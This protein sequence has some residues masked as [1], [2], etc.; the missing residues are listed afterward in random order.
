MAADPVFDAYGA[1]Y[2]LFYRDKPYDREVAWLTERIRRYHPSAHTLLDLGCGTGAYTERFAQA[3][4][5]VWGVDLSPQMIERAQQGKASY[6]VGDARRFQAE[7]PVDIATLLFHVM[8]YQSTDDDVI[9]TLKT[10]YDNLKEGGLLCF[11]VWHKP[12]VLAQRPQHRIKTC[13]DGELCVTR[14]ATPV[15]HARQHIVDVQY[16]ITVE[17]PMQTSHFDEVHRMRYFDEDELRGFLARAGFS[18]LEAEELLTGR[19]P[20]PDTWGVCY[21]ARRVTKV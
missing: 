10:C 12:A 2:D 8:S 6:L 21:F 1:Y 4:Y 3:G 11:D 7:S 19:A 17:T 18:V 20:S 16:H 14:E 9:Q 13:R 15:Q 5:E